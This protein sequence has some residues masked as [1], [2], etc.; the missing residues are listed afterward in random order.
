VIV[1]DDLGFS[2]L[3]RYRAEIATP[4]IDSLARTGLALTQF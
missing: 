4:K 2:D 3:G 1:A